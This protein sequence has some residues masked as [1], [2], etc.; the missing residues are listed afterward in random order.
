MGSGVQRVG[1]LG[2]TFDPVHAG[3]LHMA[4]AAE[5]ACQLSRI[6]F[7][8]AAAPWHRGKPPTASY[9]DRFAM[10]AL[11]LNGRPHWMPL[12]VPDSTGRPTYTIDQLAWMRKHGYGEPL[13]F[14]LGADS[15]ATLPSWR[16]W[17]E[18]LGQ[19][20]WIVL[21]RAAARHL[22]D[23]VP[24]H[25]KAAATRDEL[26]LRS[27]TRIHWLAHFEQPASASA[28]R[29]RLAGR[30]K[31]PVA[32]AVARYAGRAGLYQIHG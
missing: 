5:R 14:I 21:G 13:Y 17:R 11:A 32:A 7:V 24:A 8:P 19:C 6:Y 3:H 27:G 20:H 29:E 9:A 25:M 18:L 15:F 28:V 22:P 10:L 12:A 23:V 16:R 2:G 30:G 31:A 4:R 26:V 1:V